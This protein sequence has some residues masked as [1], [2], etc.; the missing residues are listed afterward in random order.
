[1]VSLEW[2]DVDLHRKEFTLRND[3][4]V[5]LLFVELWK[6]RRLDTIRVFLYKKPRYSGSRQDLR[7][8]VGSQHFVEAGYLQNEQRKNTC[9]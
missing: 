3:S 8:R 7:R 4:G 9:R 6:K 1:M 5:Y 2:S